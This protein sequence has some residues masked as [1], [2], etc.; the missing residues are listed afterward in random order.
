MRVVVCFCNNPI[1]QIK[2]N[3]LASEHHIFKMFVSN[4]HN[5]LLIMGERDKNVDDPMLTSQDIKR[6]NCHLLGS[7]LITLYMCRC[8]LIVK[9]VLMSKLEPLRHSVNAW[10]GW[11]QLP[12]G[13]PQESLTMVTCQLELKFV[14]ALG[15]HKSVS[16]L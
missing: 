5:T 4:P 16:L 1:Q 8:N 6:T 3:T 15:N 9:N 7:Y 14:W 11:S 13:E 10:Q 2:G 12:V